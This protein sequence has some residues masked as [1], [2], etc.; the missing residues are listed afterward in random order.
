MN[1]QIISAL[2][3]LGIAVIS[4]TTNRIGNSKLKKKVITLE[5]YFHNDDTEYYVICPNCGTKIV[6]NRAKILY[7]KQLA[8]TV[9]KEEEGK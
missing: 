5:E 9:E 1:E 6:L 4:Y 8:D 7:D 2:I 3:A